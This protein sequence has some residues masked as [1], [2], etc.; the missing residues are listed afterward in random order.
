MSRSK[1]KLKKYRN[2]K[3]VQKRLQRKLNCTVNYP[4]DT[5]IVPDNNAL[6]TILLCNNFAEV[7]FIHNFLFN[8]Q[9]CFSLE[10]SI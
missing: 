4:D 3:K 8:I 10:S 9:Y 6:P 1:S 2:E 7:T 5:T